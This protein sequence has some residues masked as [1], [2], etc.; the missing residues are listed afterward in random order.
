MRVLFVEFGSSLSSPNATYGYGETENYIINVL[1]RLL[2][3]PVL[4]YTWNETAP[5]P[6]IGCRASC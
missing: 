6:G 3:N 1:A 5:N 4:N 2:K